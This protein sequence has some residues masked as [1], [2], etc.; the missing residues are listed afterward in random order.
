MLGRAARFWHSGTVPRPL[1][2]PTLPEPPLGPLPCPGTAR[3]R[4]P[5][6]GGERVPAGEQGQE[7]TLIAVTAPLL[8][9]FLRDGPR[10]VPR[11][12][13]ARQTSGAA[14]AGSPEHLWS[15]VSCVRASRGDGKG[16]RWGRPAVPEPEGTYGG[17]A[18]QPR[19]PLPCFSL[20]LGTVKP[21]AK[22]SLE[23]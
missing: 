4:F 1:L 8:R 5:A 23:L 18:A 22:Q 6:A 15:H 3:P 19:R 10:G 13:G 11:V 2:L 16:L 7:V 17:P 9:L 20:G 12:R 21:E 14:L